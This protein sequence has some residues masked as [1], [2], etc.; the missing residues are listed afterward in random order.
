[1][2]V[3]CYVRHLYVDIFSRFS[4]LLPGGYVRSSVFFKPVMKKNNKENRFM[5]YL[6]RTHQGSRT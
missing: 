1:M 6:N 5:F 3:G 4:L 2:R